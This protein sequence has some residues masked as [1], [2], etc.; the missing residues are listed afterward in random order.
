[1]EKHNKK[2]LIYNLRDEYLDLESKLAKAKFA[3]DT[4]ELDDKADTLLFQQIEAMRYY[5]TVLLERAKHVAGQKEDE[6]R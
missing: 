2:T 5:S 1:M 3:F 4:L 6:A